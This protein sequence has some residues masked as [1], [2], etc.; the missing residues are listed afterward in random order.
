M[1]MVNVCCVLE[2]ASATTVTCIQ[3]NR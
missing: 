2:N 1:Y 3:A